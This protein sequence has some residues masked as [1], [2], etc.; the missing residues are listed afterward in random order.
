MPLFLVQNDITTIGVDAIVNAANESLL[1]GGG[2]DGA[3]H[4]AAGPELLRECRTLGGCKTGQAKITKGYRLPARYVIHTV[5]PVW[6]GGR[7]GERELLASAYRSSLELAFAYRCKTV[8]FPLISSGVY[9]YP[10]EQA[11]KVAVDTIADFLS[12]HDMSVLLVIFGQASHI[13]EKERLADITVFL[14]GDGANACPHIPM[15]TGRTDE[16]ISQ[17][18]RRKIDEA[19]ISDAQCRKRANIAPSLFSEI[20]SGA[21]ARPSKPAVTALAIALELS[22]EQ[23]GELL[24]KAGFSLSRSSRFD[25]IVEFFISRR[26]YHI[27]EINE[28]L[29]VFGQEQLGG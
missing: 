20:L 13:I 17:M 24:K 29:F 1:G 19:G 3:I 9:G 21:C 22:W 7:S 6:R 12:S 2:V 23:A 11:L 15:Q 8:A 10:K 25:R 4:R 18:L 26:N 28:A 27:F 5:G 16:S 14:D